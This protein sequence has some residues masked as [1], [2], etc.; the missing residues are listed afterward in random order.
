LVTTEY[1]HDG[2]VKA[3]WSGRLCPEKPGNSE[4][5]TPDMTCLWTWYDSP[6]TAE[7][8]VARTRELAARWAQEGV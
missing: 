4:N 6:R 1:H 7:L 8:V 5:E 2:T 3:A